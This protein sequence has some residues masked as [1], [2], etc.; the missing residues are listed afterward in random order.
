[1]SDFEPQFLH[2][3]IRVR[4][5]ERSVKFYTEVL[6]FRKVRETTS[7][8]GNRLAFVIL[9]LASRKRDLRLRQALL[10]KIYPQRHKRIA[11]LLQFGVDFTNLV[12]VQKKFSFSS[13]AVAGETRY[14]VL[15]DFRPDQPA[16]PVYDS[17]V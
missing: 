16:L 8:A 15:G 10:I 6:G 13:R 12:L 2:C 4:D 7:P 1:M 11:A 5:I 3:R 14:L 17:R 9:P